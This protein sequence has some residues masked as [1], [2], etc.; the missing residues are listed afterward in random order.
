MTRKHDDGEIS[1][2]ETELFMQI[3]E[4]SCSDI[5]VDILPL[6]R[7]ECAASLPELSVKPPRSATI[8]ATYIPSDTLLAVL[9]SELR[10]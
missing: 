1:G 2:R 9:V 4:Q 8:T 10:R 3:S 5:M 7:E 6:M